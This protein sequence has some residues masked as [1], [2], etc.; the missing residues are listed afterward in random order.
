MAR[1][2]SDRVESVD[3]ASTVKENQSN[4]TLDDTEEGSSDRPTISSQ[5]QPQESET[6]TDDD[7]FKAKQVHRKARRD[8]GWYPP[9][10]DMLLNQN[11]PRPPTLAGITEVSG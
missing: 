9:N 6:D 1:E 11:E 3:Q 10:W 2:L 8:S 4:R 5:E 7:S